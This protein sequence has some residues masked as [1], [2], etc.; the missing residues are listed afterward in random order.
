MSEALDMSQ[1]P[2]SD[3]LAFYGALIAVASADGV[4]DE[5]EKSTIVKT[6]ED[7]SDQAKE[8]IKQY[9]QSP[10]PL[11]TALERLYSAN[12]VLRFGLMFSLI[13][14]AWADG[15]FVIAE[16]QAIALAQQKLHITETQLQAIS[17]F[18]ESVKKIQAGALDYNDV[19]RIMNEA[20]A[21]V[22]AAGIPDTAIYLQ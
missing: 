13:N 14:M 16:K 15:A 19:E 1:L 12:D 9:M 17:S 7:F 22:Q 11:G 21:G 20:I 6:M 8:E 5:K 3:L 2:E 4:I 10:P 18:I